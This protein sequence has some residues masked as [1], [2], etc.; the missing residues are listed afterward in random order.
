MKIKKIEK[1]NYFGK[2]I[3]KKINKIQNYK[4]EITK[5]I[6]N[7]KFKLYIQ[8]K[9][10]TQTKEISGGEILIRWNKNN[11]IIYP[12]KFINNLEKNRIIYKIDLFVLNKICK[13]LEEWNK[14]NKLNKIKI[15]INQS[16]KNL[17]NKSYLNLI[18]KIINK[19]NFEK[20]YLEIEL[21]ESIFIKDRNKVKELEKELHKLNVQVSID[22]FGTGYSS[23]YLLSEIQIDVIKLD[24][25]LFDN[26]ENK[27]AKIIVEAIV[28]LAKKLEIEIV[29][30]GIETEEQYRFAKELNCDE[31][32]GYYFSKA[33]PLEEF[34]KNLKKIINKKIASTFMKTNNY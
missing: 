9:Y 1:E 24:K 11:E 21:T 33:I 7:N 26:L 2:K 3:Y 31:I 17:L 6:K 4:L 18:N 19:Y 32:Q 14:N 8:P 15:S 27:K 10:N 29:A 30:E 5:A 20:K 28:N 13:K 16:Q 12:N 23:Y 22:D 34:E 25:K